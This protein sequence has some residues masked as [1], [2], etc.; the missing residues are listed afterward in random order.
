[1][2]PELSVIIPCYN[3]EKNIPEI[4]ARFAKALSGKNAELILVDNGS[5]DGTG[6]AIDSEIARTGAAFAKKANVA[7]NQG[8]GFGI[9]SGLKEAQGRVLA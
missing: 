1:M 7:K 8:Y 5:T 9:L 2:A 6:T 4:V 3:E